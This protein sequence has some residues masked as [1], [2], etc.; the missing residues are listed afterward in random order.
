MFAPVSRCVASLG[1]GSVPAPERAFEP[2]SGGFSGT[3]SALRR[4]KQGSRRS[5]AK[6]VRWEEETQRNDRVFAAF[7]GNE[8][9]GA[10]AD[11]KQDKRLAS[12][13]PLCLDTS[14]RGADSL[15]GFS[16][17]SEMASVGQGF[18]K[19]GVIVPATAGFAGLLA[20][21]TKIWRKYERKQR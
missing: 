18:T 15:R 2:L 14:A 1:W 10:C 13:P 6:R 17:E 9:Y 16:A 8:G 5:P 20:C 19:A 12:L 11:E 21:L 7:G 4:T 3:S